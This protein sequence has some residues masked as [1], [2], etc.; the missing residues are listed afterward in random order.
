MEKQQAVAIAE[1]VNN[2]IDE[3]KDEGVLQLYAA[4]FKELKLNV[5]SR[6]LIAKELKVEEQSALKWQTIADIFSFIDSSTLAREHPKQATKLLKEI[7]AI[8]GLIFPLVLPFMSVI[9]ALPQKE[10]ALLM[11]WLG[12]PTPEHLAYSIAA[13]KAKKT[14][15]EEK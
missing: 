3:E 14:K 2:T 1:L 4:K 11:E 13:K 8:I 10:A 5:K 9:I 15:K 6:K 7:A 12:K